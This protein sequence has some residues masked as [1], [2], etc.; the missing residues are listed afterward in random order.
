MCE[1]DSH[2]CRP[3]QGKAGQGQ[4]RA[5]RVLGG[6]YVAFIGLSYSWHDGA[7]VLV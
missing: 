1:G 3:R 2:Y 6:I 4:G 5:G 7:A